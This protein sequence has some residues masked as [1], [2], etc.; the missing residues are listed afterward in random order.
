MVSEWFFFW[1]MNL[2]W[3]F[4]FGL[5]ISGIIYLEK[6]Y[7]VLFAL[8]SGLNSLSGSNRSLFSHQKFLGSTTKL[9]SAEFKLLL[10]S[11]KIFWKLF[12]LIPNNSK[13]QV[14]YI[15]LAKDEKTDLSSLIDAASLRN[16]KLGVISVAEQLKS[17]SVFK[18][19]SR[20]SSKTKQYIRR[21]ANISH[22]DFKFFKYYH[23]RHCWTYFHFRHCCTSSLLSTPNILF[24]F[25][26][27]T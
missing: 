21:I 18:R 22:T 17:S 26:A 27:W 14:I 8:Q 3:S 19:F 16:A 15:K 9:Y 11:A 4:Y 5:Y 24:P 13:K 7:F 1:L 2:S 6:N 25:F 20:F 23:F 10:N 12:L